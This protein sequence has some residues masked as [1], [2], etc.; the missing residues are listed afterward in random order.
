MAVPIPPASLLC[1][2]VL[3]RHRG[4]RFSVPAWRGPQPQPQ[5]Q[6]CLC[7]AAR[8][9]QHGS[10]CAAPVCNWDQMCSG[11]S[12]VLRA[13]DWSHQGICAKLRKREGGSGPTSA[14]EITCKS[15]VNFSSPIKPVSEEYWLRWTLRWGEPVSMVTGAVFCKVLSSPNWPPPPH[16]RTRTSV[17]G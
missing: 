4:T 9:R 11:A 2:S 17:H 6:S 3:L 16:A 1:S 12:L 8:Q 10:T 13:A 15:N 5:A 14:A 7:A